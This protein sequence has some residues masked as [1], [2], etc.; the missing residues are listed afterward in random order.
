MLELTNSCVAARAQ[1]PSYGRGISAVIDV[2]PRTF[3]SGFRRLAYGAFAALCGEHRIISS[4][5]KTE[6][7]F[8]R[9]IFF[10]VWISTIPVSVVRRMS[11]RLCFVVL[12]N[13]FDVAY[14]AAS[15]KLV[16]GRF[17]GVEFGAQFHCLTTRAKLVGLGVQRVS[18]HV[19]HPFYRDGLAATGA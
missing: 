17:I 8:Q 13:F 18:A 12:P 14:L 3:A 15:L 9:G 2:K 7:A 16:V 19:N 5:R 6:A 1:Q 10:L 4:G 11:L